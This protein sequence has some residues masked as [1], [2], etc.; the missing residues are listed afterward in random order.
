MPLRKHNNWMQ[1]INLLTLNNVGIIIFVAL[2][3][4]LKSW[5][6]GRFIVSQKGAGNPLFLPISMHILGVKLQWFFCFFKL[7]TI[8]KSSLI[9]ADALSCL[10]M[11]HSFTRCRSWKVALF[12]IVPKIAQTQ[13]NNS[14]LYSIESGSRLYLVDSKN[15]SR[16]GGHRKRSISSQFWVVKICEK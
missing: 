7:I 15:W 9:I 12:H 3:L 1:V 2:F 13:T 16:L 14:S 6:S 11:P 10:A 8:N 5:S 4:A